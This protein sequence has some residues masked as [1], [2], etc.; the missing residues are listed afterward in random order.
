M[1]M[2]TRSRMLARTAIAC[3]LAAVVVPA[4]AATCTAQSGATLVPLVELYTSEGCSSCPPADRWLS[5]TFGG[6]EARRAAVLAF[7]VDYWNDLGWKDRFSSATYTDRQHQVAA[8]N[9]LS[10]VYTPQVVVQGRS[11]R[12]WQ[13]DA[14]AIDALR[15]EPAAATIALAATRTG[16]T[17]AIDAH[18]AVA[19][20][21]R[22]PGARLFIALTSDGLESAVKA[23]ENRGVRLHHDAV[24]RTLSDGAAV[25]ANGDAV[26]ATR[27][28]LPP[29][30]SMPKLVAFVQVPARGDVL[31]SLV[32]PLDA[33]VR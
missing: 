13:D 20:A 28:A 19:A 31:Q 6:G 5:T 4:S 11:V 17:V 3:A 24:V 22:R 32:L 8:A 18:A 14:G 25:D 23:G 29:D 27:L 7:H 16:D 9:R 15:K 33:C 21:A 10:F 30:G 12:D 2:N 26:L 1:A